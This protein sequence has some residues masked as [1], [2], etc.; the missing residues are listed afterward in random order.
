MYSYFFLKK[1][2][3]SIKI[4]INK[5]SKNNSNVFNIKLIN[6]FNIFFT[7]FSKNYFWSKFNNYPNNNLHYTHIFNK[8]F[9]S[10]FFSFNIK[11]NNFLILDSNYSHIFPLYKYIFGL[12]ALILQKNFFF[13]KPIYFT[14]K[15]W[16]YFFLKFCEHNNINLLFISD[17][18][19]YVNFF[20]NISDFDCSVSAIIPYNYT[21]DFIDYPLYT[22]VINNLIK[23]IYF[24]VFSQ[25]Y[26]N[27][28]NYVNFFFK[29]N[30]INLFFKYSNITLI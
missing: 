1:N 5:L 11:K 26:F 19:Y 10:F 29:R 28:F 15:T 23:L 12:N 8:N 3:Y 18:D 22:P 16:S 9:I 7:Y 13:L 30:Y 4:D 14:Q 17:F 27:S 20:R 21:D 25:I 6:Y 24:S 2:N